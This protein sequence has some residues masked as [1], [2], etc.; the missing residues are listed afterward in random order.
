MRFKFNC[1]LFSGICSNH[2]GN[3]QGFHHFWPMNIIS[4]TFLWLKD[5]CL[6]I[7]L[8]Q[9]DSSGESIRLVVNA[10]DAHR[11]PNTQSLYSLIW[12]E[13]WCHLERS[14]R[15]RPPGWLLVWAGWPEPQ[16]AWDRGPWE[17]ASLLSISCLESERR[18]SGPTAPRC[19]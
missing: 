13:A 5:G 8:I 10:A 17:Q 9:S 4:I 18:W 2:H 16:Q 11:N 3:H 15:N 1:D 7:H 6:K 12:R 19:G 14:V